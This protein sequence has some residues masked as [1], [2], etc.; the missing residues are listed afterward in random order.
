VDEDGGDDGVQQA[1]HNKLK[2]RALTK[3]RSTSPQL[4]GLS[5]TTS[6]HDINTPRTSN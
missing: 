2:L 5:F 1:P 4:R 6:L 3:C